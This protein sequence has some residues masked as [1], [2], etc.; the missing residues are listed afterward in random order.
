MDD[1]AE[2]EGEQ[3][4]SIRDK[5]DIY[6]GNEMTKSEQQTFRI[7]RLYLH[8]NGSTEGLYAGACS[9]DREKLAG[10]SRR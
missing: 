6:S 3:T 7:T 4:L 8:G 5:R 1:D 10:E 2:A 9:F